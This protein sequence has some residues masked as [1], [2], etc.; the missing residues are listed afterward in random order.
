MPR[1]VILTGGIGSGKSVVAAMLSERGI[2]VYD[3][4]SRTKAL[5]DSEPSL[6]PAIEE[7]LGVSLRKGADGNCATG[8]PKELAHPGSPSCPAPLDRRLLASIIFNDMA[9]REKLEAVVY[10]FVLQDFLRWKESFPAAPFVVLESAV[11]L[12]KPAFS[13]LADAATV[14]L[15]KASLQ[16]RLARVQER[17]G[18]SPEE[19]L[20]RIGS[21]DPVPESRADIVIDNSGSLEDLSTAVAS[22]YSVLRCE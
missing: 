9:A 5:Y 18:S 15:V 14:V 2:P 6:V 16:V 7:A 22:A 8:S 1:T 19:A 3:S 17:D 20:A 10:P 13:A 4:D 12:S 21:Q 11:I